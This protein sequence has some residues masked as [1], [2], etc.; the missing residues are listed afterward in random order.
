MSVMSRDGITF[1]SLDR[2]LF[3]NPNDLTWLAKGLGVELSNLG[4]LTW[5]I[6]IKA[7]Q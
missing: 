7:L 4:F 1:V 2:P 5:E 6:I 3:L